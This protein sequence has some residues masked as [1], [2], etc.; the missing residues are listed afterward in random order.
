MIYLFY[1]ICQEEPKAGPA[2]T[3]YPIGAASLSTSGI[4]E[5]TTDKGDSLFYFEYG[6]QRVNHQGDFRYSL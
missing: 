2:P 5:T 1:K 4:P 3:Y 6:V